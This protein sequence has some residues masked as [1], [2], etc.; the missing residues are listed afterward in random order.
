MSQIEHKRPIYS[1]RV[2]KK[3]RSVSG[4]LYPK[5]C[6]CKIRSRIIFFNCSTLQQKLSTISHILPN[7]SIKLWGVS[8]YLYLRTYLK[9]LFVFRRIWTQTHNFVPNFHSFDIQIYSS[10]QLY[11]NIKAVEFSKFYR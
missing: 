7:L 3:I 2:A 1:K 5:I 11:P 9:K 8:R 10:G 4:Y 6:F